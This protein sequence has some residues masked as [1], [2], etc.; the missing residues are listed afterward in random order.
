MLKR[1]ECPHSWCL[2]RTE[3]LKFEKVEGKDDFGAG[4]KESSSISGCAKENPFHTQPP[5]DGP[6]GKTTDEI[7]RDDSGETR[8]ITLSVSGL[9]KAH[10]AQ[11][12]Q[13]KKRRKSWG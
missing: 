5:W 6:T 3:R 9:P 13:I 10:F 4:K 8:R 1:R 7:K 12:G 2:L 11:P